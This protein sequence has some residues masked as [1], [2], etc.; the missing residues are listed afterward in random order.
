MKPLQRNSILEAS[1]SVSACALAFACLVLCAAAPRICFADGPPAL[2]ACDLLGCWE[3]D[4]TNYLTTEQF[5]PVARANVSLVPT[6][7]T[8]EYA[9]EINSP[10][11]A[12][13][14][15]NVVE[16]NNH[17][18]LSWF[19]WDGLVWLYPYWSSAN[20]G[21]HGP[22]TSAAHRSGDLHHQREHWL[23]EPL[24]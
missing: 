3:F 13:L 9:V 15:Y 8:G 20:R 1:T 6:S 7:W 22:G 16:T 4:N 5:G 14:K 18:N 12:Y 11:P 17:S 2:P 19:G 24:P 23:V 10:N 21:G